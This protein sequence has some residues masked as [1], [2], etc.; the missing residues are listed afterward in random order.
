MQKR[1]RQNKY[2]ELK[3]V[4]PP[5][6]TKLKHRGKKINGVLKK[7]KVITD[8]TTGVDLVVDCEYN[9]SFFNK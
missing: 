3:G 1:F 7:L 8:K 4:K 5:Y 6:I 9:D 2:A